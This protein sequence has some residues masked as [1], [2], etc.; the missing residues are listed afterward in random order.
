MLTKPLAEAP[1]LSC[2]Q[3]LAC[4]T[5]SRIALCFNERPSAACALEEECRDVDLP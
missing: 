1:L 3:Q 5:E 2:L 4:W